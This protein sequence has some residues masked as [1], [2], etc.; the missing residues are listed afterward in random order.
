[1]LDADLIRVLVAMELRIES[2][3]I[4]VAGIVSFLGFVKNVFWRINI[5][6]DRLKYITDI[7]S[8]TYGSK[9]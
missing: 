4:T 6:N 2:L 1:M 9:E 5:R 7:I 3:S 8:D